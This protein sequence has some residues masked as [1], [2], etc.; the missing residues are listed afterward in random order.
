MERNLATNDNEPNHMDAWGYQ[1]CTEVYQPMPANGIT[2]FEVPYT[3]NHT[4]Y[5]E[6]CRRRWGVTPRPNWEEMTFQSDVFGPTGTNIF[7][8]NG[9]LDPWRAAGIQWQPKGSTDET[10]KVRL[11][12]DGAHHL[13]LRAPHPLDPP[14]VVK[15]R[16]EQVQEIKKWV[17]EWRILHAT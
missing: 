7:L 12:E 4:A 9:Q 10:I 5:F 2:D 14:S 1:T 8:T 15:V 17:K 3:P 6:E 16:K 11:I 13:D